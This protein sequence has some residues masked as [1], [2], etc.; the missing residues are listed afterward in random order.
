M[1]LTENMSVCPLQQLANSIVGKEM[2]SNAILEYVGTSTV[3]KA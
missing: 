1:L 3:F 2:I